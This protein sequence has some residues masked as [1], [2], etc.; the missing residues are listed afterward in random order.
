VLLEWKRRLKWSKIKVHRKP[1]DRKE[2]WG[3]INLRN[4]YNMQKYLI[5]FHCTTGIKYLPQT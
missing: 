1:Y 4:Y 2:N 5:S 3:R